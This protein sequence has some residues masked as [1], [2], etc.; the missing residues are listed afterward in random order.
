[1]L[2]GVRLDVDGSAVGP[3]PAASVLILVTFVRLFVVDALAVWRAT[4]KFQLQPR[5][6]DPDRGT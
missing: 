2:A 3:T 5:P 1:M 4:G 6:A